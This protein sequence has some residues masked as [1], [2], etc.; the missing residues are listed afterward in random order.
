MSLLANIFVHLSCSCVYENYFNSDTCRLILIGPISFTMLKLSRLVFY[1]FIYLYLANIWHNTFIFIFSFAT[2]TFVLYFMRYVIYGHL[3]IFLLLLF[4]SPMLHW[5]NW[6][7]VGWIHFTPL[8]QG[9][10]ICNPCK[11]PVQ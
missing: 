9:L 11:H 2:S 8:Y 3:N 7:V 5:C 4:R 6:F 10:E 1:L